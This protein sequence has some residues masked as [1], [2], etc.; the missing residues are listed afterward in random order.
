MESWK[1]KP[2][3]NLPSV[4]PSGLGLLV[5]TNPHIYNSKDHILGGECL[6]FLWEHAFSMYISWLEVTISPVVSHRWHWNRTKTGLE[7]H[8]ARSSANIGHY[9]HT[10]TNLTTKKSSPATA[11]SSSVPAYKRIPCPSGVYNCNVAPSLRSTGSNDIFPR[12]CHRLR[13]F[14]A[15]LLKNNGKYCAVKGGATNISDRQNPK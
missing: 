8:D 10:H 3:R 6:S 13:G 15:S 12:S 4:T 5:L 2:G 11:V 9:T 1:G 7:C 14:G